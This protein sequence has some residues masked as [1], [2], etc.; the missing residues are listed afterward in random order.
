[1]IPQRD[2]LEEVTRRI[3]PLKWQKELPL[4]QRSLTLFKPA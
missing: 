2:I 1:M 3:Y 4:I